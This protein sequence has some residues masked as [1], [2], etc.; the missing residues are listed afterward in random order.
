M[1]T[2]AT[3]GHVLPNGVRI[4]DIAALDDAMQDGNHNFAIVLSGGIAS[5]KTIETTDTGYIVTSHI[6]N[7]TM[8]CTAKQLLDPK[9]SNIAEAMRKGAFV[10]FA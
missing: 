1:K 7:T 6:D 2:F 4:P 3:Q 10:V 9:R 5:R 8:R